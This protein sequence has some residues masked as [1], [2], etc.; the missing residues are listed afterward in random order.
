[1]NNLQLKTTADGSSTIYHKE[2]DEH[3]HSIHGALQ[4]SVHVFIKSG[5]NYFQN[6]YPFNKTINI[7]EV[8]WGTGLN[9]ILS[10]LCKN[11]LNQ[12]IE[13]SGIEPYPINLDIIE[14]LNF[15]FNEEEIKLFN[16]IHELK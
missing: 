14:N 1:M 4:E 3:Y 15:N 5:L 9:C 12:I 10:I 16:N 11:P 13:Y 2:L 6:K 8:G 7:L